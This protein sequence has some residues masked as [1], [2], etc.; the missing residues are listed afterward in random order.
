MRQVLEHFLKTTDKQIVFT[1]SKDFFTNSNIKPDF[2]FE[3]LSVIN[4]LLNQKV[5]NAD[6]GLQLISENKLSFCY[7]QVEKKMPFILAEMEK[8]GVFISKPKLEILKDSV[9]KTINSLAKEIITL[10]GE[11]FNINSPKQL[12][13]ILFKKLGLKST[14]KTAGGE[15]STSNDVLEEL[16][17]NGALIAEKL[18]DY[19]H[20]SKLLNTYIT[21]LLEKAN[22]SIDGRIRTTFSSISTTTGRLNSKNPNLQNLPKK[23]EIGIKIK[24][25]FEGGDGKTLISFDYSQIELRILAHIADVKPLKEAFINGEDIHKATASTM[26]EVPIAMVTQN[27]RENAKAI[28]F[29][30]IYGLS[31]FA[32]A[33]TLGVSHTKAKEYMNDYFEKYEGI[34]SY[35]EET[36]K[37]S[38]ENGFVRTILGKKCYLEGINSSNYSTRA[39]AIR[40]G[41]NARI[42]GSAADL[43]KKAM[44]NLV[45]IINPN[46]QLV[47]QIHDELVFEI[48]DDLV[49]E[50]SLKIKDIMEGAIKLS[51]PISVNSKKFS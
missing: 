29:G 11:D 4:Y 23:T 46:C 3:D 25:C 42:Q 30:I 17:M 48:K 39:H 7:H 31:N 47:L 6:V 15:L 50:Y 32:L 36:E 33:K 2:N 28:N 9:N 18:I 14:Q 20:L 21:V 1:N 37:L 38:K 5:L 40:A 34:K 45:D 26:F 10:A 8:L 12:N 27:L 35:M 43:I 41:I 51:V 13:E 49:E 44:I 19:R 22:Q 24:E 16:A